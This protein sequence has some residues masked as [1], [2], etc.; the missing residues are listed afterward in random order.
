MDTPSKERLVGAIIFVLL[1]VLLVP[2]I[3][4]GP[5]RA[6]A[7][8]NPASVGGTRSYIINLGN[9]VKPAGTPGGEVKP[10]PVPAPPPA[11]GAQQLP[12]IA[13]GA[14]PAALAPAPTPAPVIEAPMLKEAWGA[15][16]GSFSKAENAQRLVSTLRK[17]GY[18]AFDSPTGTGTHVL[19]RVRVGPESTRDAAEALVTRLKRDGQ[20]A[21]VVSF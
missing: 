6:A 20:N 1:I 15:Q 3:L 9:P 5:H 7:A 8:G 12:A 17:K 10:A 18:H 11:A 16:L 14:P 19:H 13:P 2:E 4:T 21:T